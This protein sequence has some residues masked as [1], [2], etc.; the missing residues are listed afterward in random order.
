MKTD[1]GEIKGVKTA[2]IFKILLMCYCYESS[3]FSQGKAV[4]YKW[5]HM[6][7]KDLLL[8]VKSNTWLLL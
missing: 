4:L 6:S 2:I 3:G 5:A 1:A 7:I 8:I